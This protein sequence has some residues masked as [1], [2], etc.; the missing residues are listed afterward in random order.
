MFGVASWLCFVCIWL[1]SVGCVLF[2]LF[3]SVVF[4]IK[5]LLLVFHSNNKF[6]SWNISSVWGWC[7]WLCFVVQCLSNTQ[8][9]VGCSFRLLLWFSVDLFLSLLV[10]L[11]AVVIIINILSIYPLSIVNILVLIILFVFVNITFIFFFFIS[12]EYIIHFS[13][14]S[15]NFQINLIAFY[16]IWLFRSFLFYVIHYF[17]NC[18]QNCGISVIIF[19]C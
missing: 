19:I 14:F 2:H 10:V 9:F 11:L 3:K 1:G 17:F 13:I 7:W 12:L 6:K 15:I 18:C 16:S 5:L 8:T 4:Q